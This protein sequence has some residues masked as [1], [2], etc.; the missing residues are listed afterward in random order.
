MGFYLALQPERMQV[1][2]WRQSTGLRNDWQ[3]H[4]K[5]HPNLSFVSAEFVGG[6]EPDTRMHRRQDEPAVKQEVGSLAR[7]VGGHPTFESSM[8][9]QPRIQI[10]ILIAFGEAFRLKPSPQKC[11][12]LRIFCIKIGPQKHWQSILWINMDKLVTGMVEKI[13]LFCYTKI[14]EVP[15][16][17]ISGLRHLPRYRPAASRKGPVSWETETN[18]SC[19]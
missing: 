16:H 11:L 3:W 4:I 1:V 7:C 15:D 10:W 12:S 6:S 13:I 8:S 19:W 2:K 9:F 5:S 18:G 17:K 14:Y